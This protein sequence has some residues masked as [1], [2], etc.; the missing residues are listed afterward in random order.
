MKHLSLK[1]VCNIL[2]IS[3]IEL[4]SKILITMNP[5]NQ[6]IYNIKEVKEGAIINT[7]IEIEKLD[8]FDHFLKPF[9]QKH[10]INVD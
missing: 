1:L 8:M 9:I 5:I 2:K 10:K 3:K 4:Y 7:I 6:A